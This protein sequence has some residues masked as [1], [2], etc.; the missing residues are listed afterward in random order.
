[1]RSFNL[2]KNCIRHNEWSGIAQMHLKVT[3]EV[4]LVK[5]MSE[6][7]FKSLILAK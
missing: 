3:M 4:L 2:P 5:E 1:V 7:Q 6:S